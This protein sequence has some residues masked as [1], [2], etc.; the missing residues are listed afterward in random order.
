MS[1]V[2]STTSR[3][4]SVYSSSNKLTGSTIAS[5]KRTYRQVEYMPHVPVLD[6]QGIPH[7][8]VI[9]TGN[10]YFLKLLILLR[11]YLYYNL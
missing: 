7:I 1:R 8:Y 9:N 5:S 3:S 2:R 10:G 11:D 6:D 4:S